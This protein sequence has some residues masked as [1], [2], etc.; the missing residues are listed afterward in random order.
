MHPQDVENGSIPRIIAVTQRIPDA[1]LFNRG[2][3]LQN[4]LMGYALKHS[5]PTAPR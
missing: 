1:A 4:P 2:P 5:R 3:T